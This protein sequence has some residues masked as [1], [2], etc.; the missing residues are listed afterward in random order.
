MLWIQRCD[1]IESLT[2]MLVWE[3]FSKGKLLLVR[4][5]EHCG[6]FLGLLPLKQS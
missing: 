5:K 4:G 1:F 2:L 6:A 3:G